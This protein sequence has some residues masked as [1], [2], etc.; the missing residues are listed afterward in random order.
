MVSSFCAVVAVQNL[1]G[2]PAF[3][4]A[5][6]CNP[7]PGSHDNFCVANDNRRL[8]CLKLLF[9]LGARFGLTKAGQ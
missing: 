3:S 9:R 1:T 6:V 4:V 8:D 7:P 2:M 5:Q